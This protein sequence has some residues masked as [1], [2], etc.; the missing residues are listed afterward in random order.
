MVCFLFQWIKNNKQSLWSKLENYI[1]FWHEL[2]RNYVQLIY[3]EMIFVRCM[4][5]FDSFSIVIRNWSIFRFCFHW[6]LQVMQPWWLDLCTNRAEEAAGKKFF[7]LWYGFQLQSAWS[8]ISRFFSLVYRLLVIPI[9]GLWCKKPCNEQLLFQN[10]FCFVETIL[11]NWAH[12]IYTNIFF[13][14][15]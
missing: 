14:I 11:F 5:I 6:A 7:D 10:L 2:R 13:L 3:D 4:I 9:Y 8:H 1:Y 12:L 15:K